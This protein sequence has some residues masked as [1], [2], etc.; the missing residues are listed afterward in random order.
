MAWNDRGKMIKGGKTEEV[1]THRFSIERII[2]Y[3]FENFTQIHREFLDRKTRR[4]IANIDNRDNV[5]YING[6]YKDK[7]EYQAAINESKRLTKAEKISE[8]LP[9]YI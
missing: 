3:K 1:K 9:V 2:T 8:Y 5:L 6:N 7:K 4:A